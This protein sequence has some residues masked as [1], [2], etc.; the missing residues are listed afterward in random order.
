MPGH[1]GKAR[2][3]C[4]RFNVKENHVVIISEVARNRQCERLT[5]RAPA[6]VLA[7]KAVRRARHNATVG[8]D[9]DTER[10]VTQFRL[11][12]QRAKFLRPRPQRTRKR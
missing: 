11:D 2:D 10:R 3:W 4:A 9:G 1:L 6:K 5:R 7:L 8:N 12:D